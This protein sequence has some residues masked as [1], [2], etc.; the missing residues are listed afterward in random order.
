MPVRTRIILIFSVATLL[1][2]G[3]VGTPALVLIRAD[4]QRITQIHRTDQSRLW[5]ASVRLAGLPLIELAHRLAADAEITA[6]AGSPDILNARL[7][8]ALAEQDRGVLRIDVVSAAGRVAGSSAGRM[9]EEP[10]ADAVPVLRE[11]STQADVLGVEIVSGGAPLLVVS[12]PFTG[13][14][15]LALANGLRPAVL[16]M[17]EAT[18][19]D[20]FLKDTKGRIIV[21][22]PGTAGFDLAALSALARSTGPVRHR[23]R[24]FELVES[25]V[26]G[27]GGN[28]IASIVTIRDVTYPMQQRLLLLL[29]V[30]GAAALLTAAALVFLYSSIRAALEP[31]DHLAGAVRALA[32]GDTM[33][34]VDVPRRLDEI[35][36]IA[37][38]VEVF[39]RHAIE[40]ERV[41]FLERLD[42]ARDETLIHREMTGMAR[43]L[44]PEARA[45]VLAD[46]ARI[47]EQPR[48]GSGGGSGDGSGRGLLAGAFRHM[49][50]RVREQHQTLSALLAERTRDLALVRQALAE[51]TQ[52]NRLREELEVARNLQLSS[53]P[54]NFPAF[55]ERDDFDLF[56]LCRP[57][58]EVG[59]DFYD[60]LMLDHDRLVLMVG[61][62]SGKGVSAAIF[63][64]QTRG[65]MRSR[66][67]RG[68][69]PA[70][71][72]ALA[73]DTL[74][75]E[76]PT[77]MFATAFLIIIDLRTLEYVY[78][79]AGHNPPFLLEAGGAITGLDRSRGTALGVMEGLSYTD[80]AGRLPQKA[81][82]LLFSDG[83]TDAVDP[84]ERIYGD[85]GVTA[86]LN[87]LSESSAEVMVHRV[88]AGIDAFAGSAEQLD[89]ITLL[90]LRLRSGVVPK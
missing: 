40:L 9:A 73:N 89:D 67:S 70:D 52:L 68:G 14:G 77:M 56:A 84:E 16:D 30:A 65:L 3:L 81:A 54:A 11:L 23:D 71:A 31:L 69:S 24:Q 62:A 25:P 1:L 37:E 61:D 58:K 76:N 46:L 57:A 15:F 13:G 38:A 79:N 43:M 39:R 64:S 7:V 32:R 50:G 44:E 66:V 41:G 83:A 90:A 87:A 22:S 12:V 36:Q 5:N 51:R 35:G 75:A 47:E 17:A 6:A 45:A 53:L 42:R 2:I 63:I 86:S 82:L 59:G 18:A 26:Q 49:V 27:S 10:L 4:D 80:I 78:A 55:P 88:L 85:D 33:I 20:S 29:S 72:L 19:S 48:N 34:S 8:R 60:F 28:P 21:A 74:S